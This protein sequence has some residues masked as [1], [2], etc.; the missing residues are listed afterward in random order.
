ML[1]P[2]AFALSGGILWGLGM[3]VLT[4]LAM[5]TGYAAEMMEALTKLY[6]GYELTWPGYI[7]SLLRNNDFCRYYQYGS[8]AVWIVCSF[9]VVERDGARSVA[10]SGG[11]LPR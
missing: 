3:A 6:P 2:K 8:C 11:V 1:N 9:V 7:T 5:Q 4:L 10:R